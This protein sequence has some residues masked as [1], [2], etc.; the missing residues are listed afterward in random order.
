MLTSGFRFLIVL[1]LLIAADA[2]GQEATLPPSVKVV[3]DM[4]QAW[5]QTTPTHQR[6]CIN[7][8]WQWVESRGALVSEFV[9]DF[10]L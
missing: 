9:G 10:H 1:T 5:Q 3:S 4:S 6:I 8:L 2:R 7:G